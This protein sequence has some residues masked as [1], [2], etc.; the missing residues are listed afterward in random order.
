MAAL[1]ISTVHT[2]N[3]LRP[4]C[5]ACVPCLEIQFALFTPHFSTPTYLTVSVSDLSPL[6]TF[7]SRDDLYQGQDLC[8]LS[9]L[10]YI[11]CPLLHGSITDVTEDRLHFNFS[12]WVCKTLQAANPVL[13]SRYPAT[14]IDRTQRLT[15]DNFVRETITH[16]VLVLVYAPGDFIFFFLARQCHTQTLT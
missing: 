4:R 16:N 2:C 11:N 3:D 15:V 12:T 5:E 10:L 8:M 13:N 1:V 14:V 7:Q 9:T 6:P